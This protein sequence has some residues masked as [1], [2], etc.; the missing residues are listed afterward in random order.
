MRRTFGVGVVLLLAALLIPSGA[1]AQQTGSEQASR[2]GQNYP[3]PFNPT[4]WI[5]FTLVD[6]DFVDG[7]PAVVSIR[8]R[9]IHLRLVAI[10]TALNHAG[11]ARVENL[12]YTMAGSQLAYWD[13]TDRTGRKVASGIYLLELFVNGERAGQPLK[14]L[15]AK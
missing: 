2:L 10:P 15:V 14:I 9:D 7:K 11:D 4:T 12:E 6:S 5:P 13:G 8:I 1:S 3:N